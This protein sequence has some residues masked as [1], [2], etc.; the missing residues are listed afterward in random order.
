MRGEELPP[1]DKE[2]AEEAR[3]QKREEML[4][5]SER[6][7]A[8]LDGADQLDEDAG[9]T[10]EDDADE[11]EAGVAGAIGEDADDGEDRRP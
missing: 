2:A 8:V 3:R 5:T 7:D 1:F 9:G 4:S 6:I 10:G 11:G